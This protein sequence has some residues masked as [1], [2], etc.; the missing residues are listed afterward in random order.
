MSIAL[1]LTAASAIA[2]YADLITAIRDMADDTAYPQASIDDAIR[3]SEAYFNRKLRVPDMET[4]VPLTVTG[5]YVAL[6]SDF[7]EM[8]AIRPVNAPCYDLASMSPAALYMT[9]R[10][11]SGTPVAY[12]VEGLQLHF[13]PVGNATFVMLYYAAIPALTNE[14]PNNWLLD[15][16][17]DAYAA[18]VMFYLAL[19]ERD[20]EMQTT[21]SGILDQ[22]VADI[23]SEGN[24]ARWGAGP[25]VPQGIQQVRGGRA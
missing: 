3:K 21:A 25:L 17:P 10:G 23:Q 15:K 22:I 4:A 20:G 5:E 19:R 9:Y 11:Q 13:G 2:N 16:H 7:R 12:A 14:I 1:D 6:P 24:A 8:R 18:A